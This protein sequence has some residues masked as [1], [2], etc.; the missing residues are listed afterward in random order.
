MR[1][2]TDRKRAQGLGSGGSGTEFHWK[3]MVRSICMGLLAPL[4]IFAIGCAIGGSF[5]DVQ[6]YFSR[7]LPAIIVALAMVVGLIQ[8]MCEAQE[9]IEDYMHGVA[10]KL[11]LVAIKAL[12]YTMIAA[13]LFALVK[14]AL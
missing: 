4:F 5:E 11:T 12:T 6:S 9:A 10:E 2:L 1:Y 3:F 14:L 8:L 13:V 7:P